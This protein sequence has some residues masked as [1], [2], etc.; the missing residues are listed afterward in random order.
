MVFSVERALRLPAASTATMPYV[1]RTASVT[2]ASVQAVVVAV[3][4]SGPKVPFVERWMAYRTTPTSSVDATHTSFGFPLTFE[5]VTLVG[6]VG[7]CESGAAIAGSCPSICFRYA[8][9]LARSG[10]ADRHAVCA[11]TAASSVAADPS[12]RYGAVS[13]TPRSVGGSSPVSGPPRRLPLPAGGSCRHRAA[14]PHRCSVKFAPPWHCA[15]PCAWKIASP[16]HAVGRQRCRRRCDAG[17]ARTCRATRHRP[18]A[19]RARRSGPPSESPSGWLRVPW[20]NTASDIS[21][22]PPASARIWPSKSCTSS[23]FALQCRNPC[24]MP[25]LPRSDTVLRRPSPSR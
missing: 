5:I 1:Y 7:A 13:Q 23:K 21:P 9:S 4:T 12:C 19:R 8:T 20:L 2:V 15:Q 3:A 18:P 25:P 17:S 24:A 16:G 10:V 14:S 22:V 6:F 11:R